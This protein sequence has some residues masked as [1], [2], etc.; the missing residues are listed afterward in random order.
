MILDT[1]LAP[2]WGQKLPQKG[3]HSS[4]MSAL[5]KLAK[6]LISKIVPVIY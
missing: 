3:A 5:Q 6:M 1:V 2:K 4:E